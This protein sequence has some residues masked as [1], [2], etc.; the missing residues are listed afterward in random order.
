MITT[1]KQKKSK[2]IRRGDGIMKTIISLLLMVVLFLG[3][4]L[5]GIDQANNGSL[6]TKGYAGG[7]ILRAV[8]SDFSQEDKYEEQVKEENTEQYKE[9]QSSHLTQKLAGELENGVK[10]FYNQ[11]V[12][13]VYQL[14]QVFF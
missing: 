8:E 11:V 10:W 14:V 2:E 5:F 6:Q 12:Y 7:E 13:T 3:G 1:G 9:I 4:V